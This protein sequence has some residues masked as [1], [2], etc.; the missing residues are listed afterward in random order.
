MKSFLSRFGPFVLFVLSGFDRL[1]L[2]GESRLLNHA[3]GVESYL[4]QRRVRFTDFPD[5]AHR[6]T[7]ELRRGTEALAA[8]HGVPL[9]HLNSPSADKE[10]AALKTARSQPDPLGRIAVLSCVES[11]AAYRLRKNPRGLIEPRKEPAKCLHYYHY[12][13]HPQL[14]LLHARLQTW[15]PF[16]IQICLNGRE[17]LARLLDQAGIGYTKKD[18]C[19]VDVADLA[20]AQTLL[21]S[22]L[23]T[24]WP[25]L[26]GGLAALSN[27]VMGDAATG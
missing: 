14:G 15:F 8:E 17:W 21:D 6:L 2:A 23:Q 11:C 4:W 13:L 27:P 24:D 22:Q 5:H 18:N 12:Y 7:G 10:A 25:A 16:T 1:R 9:L 19:F 20:S 3:R 26:L